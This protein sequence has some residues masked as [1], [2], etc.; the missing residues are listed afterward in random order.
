MRVGAFSPHHSSLFSIFFRRNLFL[1]TGRY[2]ALSGRREFRFCSI[3]LK[4][5]NVIAFPCNGGIILVKSALARCSLKNWDG[6][7]RAAKFGHG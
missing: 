2:W 3:L 1:E 6:G 4:E 7:Q 5:N